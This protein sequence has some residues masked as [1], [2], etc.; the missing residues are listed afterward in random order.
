MG[1]FKTYD[2]VV[3]QNIRDAKNLYHFNTFTERKND[4]KKSWGIINETLNK[5]KQKSDF[6]SAFTLGSR[7]LTVSREIANE[8]NTYSANVGHSLPQICV[9]ATKGTYRRDI[10]MIVNHDYIKQC[11]IFGKIFLG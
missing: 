9:G 2:R 8:F 5:G 11:I 3:N 7:T 10:K 4:M 1:K 6:P